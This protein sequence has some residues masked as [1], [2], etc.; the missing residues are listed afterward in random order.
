L[1]GMPNIDIVEVIQLP[2]NQCV[3]Q[4]TSLSILFRVL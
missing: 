3:F 2:N 4:N 1:H